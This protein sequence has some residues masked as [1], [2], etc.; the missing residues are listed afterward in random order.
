MIKKLKKM[1]CKLKHHK[2]KLHIKN[3]K[4]QFVHIDVDVFEPTLE[5][6]EF[7]YPRLIKGGIIVCDDYNGAQFPGATKAW[8]EYFKNKNVFFNYSVPLGASFII[9]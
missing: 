3:K 1:M 9:K 7:F 8:D 5:S 6:L 2:S 4:F